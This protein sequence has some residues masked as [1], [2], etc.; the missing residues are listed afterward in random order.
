[1]NVT[2]LL[3]LCLKSCNC[4]SRIFCSWSLLLLSVIINQASELLIYF[5]SLWPS[6]ICV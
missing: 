1:M 4:C 6:I 5:S 2:I 3:G